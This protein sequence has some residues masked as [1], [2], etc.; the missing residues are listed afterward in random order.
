MRSSGNNAFTCCTRCAK[1]A[2]RCQPLIIYGKGLCKLAS[3][4]VMAD[5]RMSTKESTSESAWQSKTS[6]SEPGVRP[7]EFSRCLIFSL[8]MF[9]VVIHAI[10]AVF[11]GNHSMEAPFP[12]QYLAVIRSFVLYRPL[13]LPNGLHLDGKRERC[14][15]RQVEPTCKSFTTGEPICRFPANPALSVPNCNLQLCRVVSG[16]IYLHELG[17]IHGDLKGVCLDNCNPP[18]F[19]VDHASRQISSSTTMVRPSLRTLV[20]Q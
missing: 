20:S 3:F 11:Q 12:S 1:V 9:F 14:G 2:K 7:T 18:L 5:L 10:K 16:V 15:I 8:L 13:L 6:D 17:V 4:T 19:L